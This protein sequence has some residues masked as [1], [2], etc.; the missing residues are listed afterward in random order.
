[1]E[2]SIS[3]GRVANSPVAYV[4]ILTS[5]GT[6]WVVRFFELNRKNDVLGFEKRLSA[7]LQISGS[8]LMTSSM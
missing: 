6:S 1:M 7:L 3:Y 4:G 5:V 2:L 8:A